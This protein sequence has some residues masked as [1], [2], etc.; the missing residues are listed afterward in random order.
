M[1]AAPEVLQA[2]VVDSYLEG[3]G[4]CYSAFPPYAP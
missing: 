4:C 3:S 2:H 1:L